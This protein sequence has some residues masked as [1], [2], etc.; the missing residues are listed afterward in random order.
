MTHEP[1]GVP[2]GA[3]LFG[4]GAVQS[5]NPLRSLDGVRE[6]LRRIKV[7]MGLRAIALFD[8]AL[9][10]LYATS[11]DSPDAFWNIFPMSPCWSFDREAWHRDLR[12]RNGEVCH[13]CT[14]NVRHIAKGYLIHDRWIVM[15]ML[16][17]AQP[18]EAI[19]RT[20]LIPVVLRD[21]PP[22]LSVRRRGGAEPL[23]ASVGI[24][25]WWVRGE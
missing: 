24:P 17:E 7:L 14:C 10:N 3:I 21:L 11:E 13:E 20:W 8:D 6:S 23:H 1:A 25:V 2:H 4:G 19:E 5:K 15:I 12:S 22:K 9:T 18:L 16:E